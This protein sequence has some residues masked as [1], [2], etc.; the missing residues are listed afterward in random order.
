MTTEI[1]SGSKGIILVVDDIPHNLQVLCSILGRK[2]YKIAV[3]RNGRQA[4]EVLKKIIPDLI[5]LDVMMPGIDGFEVC[6][7]IKNSPQ[8]S[9]IPIIFLTAKAETE[10]VVKGFEFGA[11]DYVAKPFNSA[12]LLARVETHLE[13]KRTRE[14]LAKKNQELIKA[15]KTLE[16]AAKTDPLTLLSNRREILENIKKEKNRYERSGRAFTLILGDLDDFKQFNDR[17]GHDCGDFILIQV[18]KIMKEMVRKQDSVARWGGEEFL[19][20]LPETH[21]E[22]GGTTAEKIKNAISKKT[23]N[24]NGIELNVSITFGVSMYGFTSPPDVDECI[25]TVDIAMYKGKQKGKNC[26]VIAKKN[27]QQED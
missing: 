3:A 23:F 17:Y 6:K 21:L 27:P 10:S 26:V 20:L 7:Q 11:V 19:L 15:K 9:Q 4:L 12:E 14:E 5:L 18:A 16:S 2:D 22:G 8:T 1:K 25:K 24:Y 13:L